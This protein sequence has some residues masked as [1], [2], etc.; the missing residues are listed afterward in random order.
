[1]CYTPPYYTIHIP[2][3]RYRRGKGQFISRLPRH[4]QPRHTHTHRLAGA[5]G[6]SML[7]TPYWAPGI[8]GE[9]GMIRC[10]GNRSRADTAIDLC[11]R[12]IRLFTSVRDFGKLSI[13]SRIRYGVHIDGGVFNQVIEALMINSDFL[14]W[15]GNVVEV[16]SG[17]R[18]LCAEW[19]MFNVTM[20]I[21]SSSYTANLLT[22]LPCQSIFRRKWELLEVH[23]PSALDIFRVS[24]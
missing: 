19:R 8:P 22:F 14:W 24:N 9:R 13:S 16:L 2:V 11:Q 7:F 20:D 5:F 17:R 10:M 4:F 21:L 1:M 18:N 23:F 3:Y 15:S 12:W 6:R